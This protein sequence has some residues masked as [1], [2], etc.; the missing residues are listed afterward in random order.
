MRKITPLSKLAVKLLP[1]CVLAVMAMPA[2]S[3]FIDQPNVKNGLR[4]YAGT[5]LSPA[6]TTTS[7]KFSYTYGD[8]T[9]YRGTNAQQIE[10]MLA[11]QDK[12]LTDD[13]LRMTG[14]SGAYL[15]LYG[16]QAIHKDLTVSAS[17]LLD[18]G[19]GGFGNYGAYWGLSADY[20][21]VGRLTV[22]GRNNGLGVGKT[23][24]TM[25][26]TLNDSGLNVVA[27]YTRIP[28]LTI[29]GYH[30]FNQSADLRNREEDGWHKSNGLSAQYTF[31][32]TSQQRVT[33]ALGGSHSKG[34]KMPSWWAQQAKAD[35]YMAG[36]SYRYKNAILSADYGIRNEKYNGV[37]VDE[38]DIK[39]YGAKLDYE[40]TPRL[41]ATLSYG[42]KGTENSRPISFEDWKDWGLRGTSFNQTIEGKLFNEVEQD[43]YSL[44]LNYKLWDNVSLNGSVTSLQTKNYLTGGQFSKR[45]ELTTTVGASFSF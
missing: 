33:V 8:P 10:L 44:G 42:H 38:I 43:R 28:D 40:F 13:E 16:A 30:M 11:D 12:K 29:A 45:E 36:L 6:F 37:L 19:E 22:G 23:S 26:N 17:V 20:D 31:S 9:I 5:S 4:F 35:A 24:L 3:V 39:T 27:R 41:T 34:H 18:G 21:R 32:P 25:L 2:H 15:E 1:A 14:V 7:R